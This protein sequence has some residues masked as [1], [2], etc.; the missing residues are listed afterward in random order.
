MADDWY[1]LTKLIKDPSIII[2][3]VK[4]KNKNVVLEGSFELPPLA[5]LSMED[6]IFVIAFLRSHGSI[7]EMEKLY[8]IS[9][10]TVK[11]RLNRIT[12]QLEFIEINPPASRNEILD[13][14]SN[15]ELSVDEAINKLRE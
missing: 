12:S 13:L 15:G 2:E 3:R 10:P 9:Y 4:I 6:Q 8:N 14:L 1:E 11:N 5:Q 7:K